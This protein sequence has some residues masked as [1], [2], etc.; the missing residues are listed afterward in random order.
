MILRHE[1]ILSVTSYER[2]NIIF[3]VKISKLT[4][5]NNFN[6]VFILEFVLTIASHEFFKNNQTFI[7]ND[8]FFRRKYSLQFYC[9]QFLK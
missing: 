9:F 3:Y 4:K 8:L 2:K 6:N 7:N 5:N 1:I